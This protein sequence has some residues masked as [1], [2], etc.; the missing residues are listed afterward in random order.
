MSLARD[1]VFSGE[2]YLPKPAI[3]R[4]V[5]E[6]N[7]SCTSRRLM[8]ELGRTGGAALRRERGVFPVVFCTTTFCNGLFR[9]P[10]ITDS[11]S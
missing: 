10:F 9:V 4:S 1:D 8:D 11:Q 6:P 3:Y 7:G 2:Q 5:F